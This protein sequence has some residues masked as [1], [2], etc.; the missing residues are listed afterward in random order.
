M[1]WSLALCPDDAKQNPV[2]YGVEF[3][4]VLLAKGP[5]TSSSVQ[6]GVNCLGLYNSGF[7]GERRFRLVTELT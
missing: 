5:R 2:V 3:S 6:K 4:V 7:E 1:V